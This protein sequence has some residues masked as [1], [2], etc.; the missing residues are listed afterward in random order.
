MVAPAVHHWDFHVD[1]PPYTSKVHLKLLLE[2][3]VTTSV[4]IVA[5]PC[6]V[7]SSVTL[8]DRPRA[9]V[10]TGGIRL[11]RPE[12]RCARIGSDSPCPSDLGSCR[13]LRLRRGTVAEISGDRS[14][15]AVWWSWPVVSSL[16]C[17]PEGAVADR[18]RRV[19][20]PRPQRPD[21][22]WR[23]RAGSSV[24]HRPGQLNTVARCPAS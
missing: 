23:P 2:Q 4:G 8:F 3:Y 7:R 16:P 9:A 24:D 6:V 22:G 13:R 12:G 11:D 14:A 1:T 21:R 17:R 10:D 15:R 20:Q 5:A 18:D 19:D